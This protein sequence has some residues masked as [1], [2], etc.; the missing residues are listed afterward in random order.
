MIETNL[1]KELKELS[2][3]LGPRAIF[4]IAI[5]KKGKIK[6]LEINNEHNF[7]YD[8]SKTTKP[9]K[10]KQRLSHQLTYIG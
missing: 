3:K 2:K 5:N 6:I 1:E 8:D 9:S 7:D 10:E 4:R